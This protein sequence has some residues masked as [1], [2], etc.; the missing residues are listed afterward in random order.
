M[1]FFD[2][3]ASK[4]WVTDTDIY[5]VLQDGR[6][7]SLP[8]KNFPLLLSA[9]PEELKKFEI[10]DGYALYWPYLGEDLS[11]AG[12]FETEDNNETHNTTALPLLNNK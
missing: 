1:N 12:F 10:I 5:V 8:V 4:V 6:Q 3:K 9:S 7:A 11:I 2:Y